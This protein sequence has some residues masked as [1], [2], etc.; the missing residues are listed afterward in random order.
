MCVCVR[1]QEKCC[2]R[3][4]RLAA[5]EEKNNKFFPPGFSSEELLIVCKVREGFFG[6][7]EM[8]MVPRPVVP[9]IQVTRCKLVFLE[10]SPFALQRD[11]AAV[12]RSGYTWTTETLTRKHQHT[13]THETLSDTHPHTHTH[14]V[15]TNPQP[16]AALLQPLMEGLTSAMLS[17]FHPPPKFQASRGKK[18]SRKTETPGAWDSTFSR[19]T[20]NSFH[21]ALPILQGPGTTYSVM[22]KWVEGGSEAC[23]ENS[24]EHSLQ[25]SGETV[26]NAV[27]P[28]HYH[29]SASHGSKLPLTSH[30]QG[31]PA[32]L[33]S[34]V[35]G[36][37]AIGNI[38]TIE[39]NRR[40]YGHQTKRVFKMTCVEAA[41]QKQDRFQQLR[42]HRFSELPTSKWIWNCYY[43]P[44]VKGHKHICV[45]TVSSNFW[46]FVATHVS[47][48]ID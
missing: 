16:V 44:N 39:R 19:Q 33:I 48:L 35:W 25:L 1:L 6:A 23:W 41:E 13:H 32:V 37:I 10:I 2:G 46:C 27:F 4:W 15:I 31:R 38:F 24:L 29:P 28:S 42:R 47:I 43:P 9:R 26:Q 45:D 30:S 5:G 20:F 11:S 7:P 21:L 36:C 3:L 14:R 17:Y 12:I 18:G 22:R 40:Y 8:Q 34:G